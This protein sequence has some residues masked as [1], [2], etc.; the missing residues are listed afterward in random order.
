MYYCIHALDSCYIGFTICTSLILKLKLHLKIH[1]GNLKES[2]ES[3]GFEASLEV[4]LNHMKV[5]RY[6][7]LFNNCMVWVFS[8]D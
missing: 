6:G 5:E 1:E 2:H 8:L 7:K 4:H 3:N